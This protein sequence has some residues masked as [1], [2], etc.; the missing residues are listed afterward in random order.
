MIRE[1]MSTNVGVERDDARLRQ[2]LATLK[3]IAEAGGGDPVID[4]ATIAARFVAEAALRRRESRGVHLRADYTASDPDQARS[5]TMTL[6][7]LSLRDSLA[8]GELF[9]EITAGGGT[10]H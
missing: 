7:G 1:T 3:D 6:A 4:N 10:L 2:A 9:S 8:S 5:R